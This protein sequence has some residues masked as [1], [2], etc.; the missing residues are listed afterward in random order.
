MVI[1]LYLYNNKYRNKK[2]YIITPE[3]FSFTAERKLMDTIDTKAITNTE[4][5]TFNRMAYRILNEVGGSTQVTLSNCGK[6]MLIVEKSVENVES[7]KLLSE[8]GISVLNIRKR[9]GILCIFMYKHAERRAFHCQ[10]AACIRHGC[11]S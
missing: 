8:P 6:S 1:P 10:P 3:Q 2:I 7:G 9:H 4:V 11:S 5:I